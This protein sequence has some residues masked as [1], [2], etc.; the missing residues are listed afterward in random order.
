MVSGPDG[1]R[2]AAIE[3]WTAEFPLPRPVPL[4]ETTISARQYVIVRVTT[5]SGYEGIAFSLTRG[6]P[7]G[8]VL[9]DLIAPV[10]VGAD[11][12]RIPQ[13][14]DRVEQKLLLLGMEGIPQRAMSLVD[15]CL[16]DIKAR[17]AGL[18]LWR[19]LGGF[20]ATSPA[21]LVDLY[22]TGDEDPHRLAEAVAA[23]ST[24][25]Y[26]A[27]KLHC[28]GDPS[29][30]AEVLALTREAVG[31]GADLVVDFGM[32]CSDPAEAVD[33]TRLW[34]RHRPAWVEDPFRAEQV[35]WIRQ[36]RDAVEVPVGAGDEVASFSWMRELIARRAVDVVRLDALA[37]GGITGFAALATLARAQGCRVSPH[38]YPEIHQH[39]AFAW[40]GITHVETFAPGTPYDCAEAFVGP[41]SLNH[42]VDGFVSAPER[43]GLGLEIDWDAVTA[44]EIGGSGNG[45]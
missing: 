12:L 6:A 15:V 14:W 19:L 18:P 31:A 22:P 9:R 21:L 10:L 42:P 5:E 11:A 16:W 2:I 26:Q 36:V 44:H 38:V 28:G 17:V 25:G 13:L 34:Q 40:P 41:D 33:A 43:P 4:G 39:C 23:R 37:H 32:E 7:I 29:W 35:D 24:E 3:A 8:L 20:R 45:D 27:F 30:F 1:H